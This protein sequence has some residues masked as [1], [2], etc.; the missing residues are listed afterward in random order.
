MRRSLVRN[1][2]FWLS[3][4]ILGISLLT[5][6]FDALAQLLELGQRGRTLLL[7]WSF[8]VAGTIGCTSII[9]IING[10]LRV[11]TGNRKV[12]VLP[13]LVIFILTVILFCYLL[14]RSFN[15]I[16]PPPLRPDETITI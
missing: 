3:G 4:S 14:L 16:A 2:L 10:A 8:F 13:A 9:I 5:F 12:P 11:A 1:G 7:F 6:N 15:E